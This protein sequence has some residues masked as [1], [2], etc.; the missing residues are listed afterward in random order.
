[1]RWL[2]ECLLV[3]LAALLMA[4]AAMAGHVWIHRIRLRR[5]PPSCFDTTQE[6][7]LES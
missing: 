1:M 7:D 4:A 3:S 6:T 2:M 5:E